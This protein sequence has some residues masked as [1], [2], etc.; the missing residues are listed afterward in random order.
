MLYKVLKLIEF[1]SERARSSI[2]VR[3]PEGKI[4]MYTKGADS[5]IYDRLFDSTTE[6]CDKTRKQ[7]DAFSD[8]GLRTLAVGKRELTEE[9]YKEWNATYHAASTALKDREEKARTWDLF[10]YIKCIIGRCL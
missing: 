5:V 4:V 7:I 6:V 9:E 10:Y 2:I 8:G 1:S 3:T